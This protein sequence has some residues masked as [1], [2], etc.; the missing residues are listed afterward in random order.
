[1]GMFR[2]WGRAVVRLRWWVVAAGLVL[3]VAGATWGSGVFGALS[4]GGYDDPGSESNR[5][6]RAI[7]EQLGRRDPDVLVLWYRDSAT[8]D[9]PGVRSAI[10][11]AVAAMRARPEVTSVSSYLDG[12]SP[13]LVSNDR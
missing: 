4:G 11:A 13:A 5:A 1:M 6:M 10:T 8:V 3:V 12:R 9:D 2:W 7:A